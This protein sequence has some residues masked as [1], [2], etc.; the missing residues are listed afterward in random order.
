MKLERVSQLETLSKVFGCG[1]RSGR[2]KNCEC[3]PLSSADEFSAFQSSDSS[4]MNF[5]G[6]LEREDGKAQDWSHSRSG[7][8]VTKPDSTSSKRLSVL[9]ELTLCHLHPLPL[10]MAAAAGDMT[11]AEKRSL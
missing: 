9:S 6:T 8:A 11:T 10:L 2:D 5:I 3:F 4:G 1:K 7:L